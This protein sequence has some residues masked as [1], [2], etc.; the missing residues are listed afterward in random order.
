METIEKQELAT[1]TRQRNGLTWLSLDYGGIMAP[2]A[3]MEY[4]LNILALPS[5]ENFMAISDEAWGIKETQRDRTVELSQAEVDQDRLIAEAKAATGRAK[6]A[7]ERAADEYVL[8]AK[9][10][11]AKVKGLI[12]GA[13][14]YAALVEEEQLAVEEDRAG[15]AIDKEALRL[16]K[17][18]ADIYL[19]T[20]AQAQV[21]ADL[22][23]AQVEVAKAHV[24]AAMAGIEAG[25]AEIKLIAA[26]TEVFIAEAQKAELQADVAN[27]YA[28]IMTKKLSETKLGVGR[29]E[30]AAGYLYIQSKLDDALVLYGTRALIETIKTEAETALKEELDLFLAVEKAEQDL[31]EL[32]TE[33]ARLTLTHEAGATWSNISQETAMRQALVTAR[34]N[35]NN[36]RADKTVGISH[37]ETSASEMVSYARAFAAKFSRHCKQERVN[38]TEYI[39]GKD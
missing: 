3:G 23:K 32:E 9:I 37:A 4:D 11:D 31:R 25:E 5:I 21:E 12:M 22:A 6:I 2:L 16:K 17:V 35:V 1:R 14:E 26:Q 27:I 36:A 39:S 28:E 38:F 7:I 18:K 30:I 24:R 29:A 13:K 20:I 34:K 15:L 10:Y 8:A 33:Y 19:E